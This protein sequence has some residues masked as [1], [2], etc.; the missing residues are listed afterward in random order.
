MALMQGPELALNM[1]DLFAVLIRDV[2]FVMQGQEFA[3]GMI[4]D[5]FPVVCDIRVPVE[6][7]DL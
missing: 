2:R 7:K 3:A 1:G 4:K 5:I 6:G